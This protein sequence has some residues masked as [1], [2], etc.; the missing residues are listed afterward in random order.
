[1]L[2]LGYGARGGRSATSPT[3]RGSDFGRLGSPTHMV[4]GLLTDGFSPRFR[5]TMAYPHGFLEMISSEFGDSAH[6]IYR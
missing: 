1:M 3:L 2:R 5:H 6:I 4:V